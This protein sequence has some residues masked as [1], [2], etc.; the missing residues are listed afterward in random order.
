MQATVLEVGGVAGGFFSGGSAAELAELL[1]KAAGGGGT[2]SL[3][4]GMSHIGG[5]GGNTAGSS[6]S[7]E[8]Q[9]IFRA[10]WLA[11]G[12]TWR[13]TETHGDTRR[14]T[15]T[16]GDARRHASTNGDRRRHTETH[17]DTRSHTDKVHARPTL[18]ISMAA[19]TVPHIRLTPLTDVISRFAHK[20]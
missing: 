9:A 13:H 19:L 18:S 15:A 20:Q 4:V 12:D 10:L 7:I 2:L 14:H 16:H 17:G 1:G 6:R 8:C 5:A 11:H 3:S